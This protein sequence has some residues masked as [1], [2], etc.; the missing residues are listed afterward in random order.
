MSPHDDP[1]LTTWL[2]NAGVYGG[3]F[4]HT[5]AAAAFQADEENYALL[6][7]VLLQLKAKYPRYND[8]FTA[9]F[10]SHHDVDI[11]S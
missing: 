4:V 8:Y 5:I 2:Q 7:S 10:R 3:G 11:E 6:R 1:E 9:R